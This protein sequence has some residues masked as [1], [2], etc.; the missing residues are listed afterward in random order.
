MEIGTCVH[1]TRKV[2]GKLP[3]FYKKT[4]LPHAISPTKND[5]IVSI[6]IQY[7]GLHNAIACQISM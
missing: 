4:N 3:N 7:K 2:V 1:V 6:V 5:Y